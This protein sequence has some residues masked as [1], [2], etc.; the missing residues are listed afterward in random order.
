[1]ETRV[2]IRMAIRGMEVRE[3]TYGCLMDCQWVGN[4]GKGDGD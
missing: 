2:V 1:M 3:W 4:E